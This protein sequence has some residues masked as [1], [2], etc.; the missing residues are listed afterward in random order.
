M[1]THAHTRTHTHTHAP[2]HAQTEG[3]NLAPWNNALE[4]PNNFRLV[5]APAGVGADSETSAI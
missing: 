5:L 3:G 1:H 4:R 2:T